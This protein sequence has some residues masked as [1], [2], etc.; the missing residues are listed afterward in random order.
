MRLLVGLSGGVDSSVAILWAR[1]RGFDPVGCLL[2]MRAPG[3]DVP[4]PSPR[5]IERARATC[6]GL[7]VPFMVRDVG[8]AFFERVMA[9]FATAYARG[10]TPN[11]CTLCNRALKVEELIRAADEVGADRVATGHY[12]RLVEGEDGVV[13]IARGRDGAKDQSYFLARLSPE[14]AERLAFPLADETKAEV[15][16]RALDHG[17]PAASEADSEGVCF[18]PDGDYRQVLERLAPESLEPGPIVSEE[19]KALGT[20]RGIASY[21]VGQRRGL[22]L[23]GGPWFVKE[24]VADDATIVVGHGD[25]PKVARLELVDV[26]LNVDEGALE[27]IPVAVQ[28]HYRATARPVSLRRGSLGTAEATFTEDPVLAAPGQ[29]AALYS[30][31]VV[32]GEGTISSVAFA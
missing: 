8:E 3:P 29:S 9:P 32:I 27:A 30:E 22:G 5:A 19:G 21:T 20:H 26:T 16:R 31:D 1:E 18:A 25:Q 7:G 12:A 28:T 10:L 4:V 17:L 24:I 2:V 15:R 6:E 11:P 14:Q 23:S 13:R